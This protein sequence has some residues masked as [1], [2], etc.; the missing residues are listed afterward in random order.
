MRK[1]LLIGA[2][3]YIGQEFRNFKDNNCIDAIDLT[4]VSASNR[5]WEDVDFSQF[6]TI[7][8]LSALVHK[9]E[10]KQME[11]DYYNINY[12]LA[13][14]I[15]EKARDN[16]IKH[17]IF[18]STAAVFDPRMNCVMK[19]TAPNPLSL[20]G[21]SKLAAENAIRS[22]NSDD[23]EVAIVRI[24][25]VYGDRCKGN[26][27]RLM[28]LA[29]YIAIIPEFHNRRSAI[30]INKLCGFLTD[31]II[32]KKNG[33]FYPQDEEYMDT[34]DTIVK[35]RKQMGK[36]T[37]LTNKFNFLIKILLP[38]SNTLSKMFGDFYYQK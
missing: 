24:P 30:H 13:V 31:L 20:Y 38:Y 27:Q 23:F 7:M 14:A 18:F 25:M 9:K 33:Y 8:H 29:K 35:I 28:K 21:K 11:F 2:N 12:K 22:M 36:R 10:N 32:N 26:Y 37:Y 17:F 19:D 5:E 16:N 34:C 3:S 1:V 15:A 4:L 6:D